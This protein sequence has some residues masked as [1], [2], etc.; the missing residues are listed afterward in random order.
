VNGEL[1]QHDHGAGMLLG[2][3]ELLALLS[4]YV[5]LRPGDVVLTGTPAG[6]GDE[7]KTYLAAGDVVEV[8]VADLPP[9]RTSVS[10]A[11]ERAAAPETSRERVAARGIA[12]SS[13]ALSRGA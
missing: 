11:A 8:V 6:T 12:S 5:E 10:A 13:S 7:T 2:V 1:R 9:M 3:G 4:R